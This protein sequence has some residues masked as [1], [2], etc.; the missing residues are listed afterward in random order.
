VRLHA[1]EL[2]PDEAGQEAVRRDWRALRE[3]G[4]PSQLDHPGATNAPHLTLVAAPSVEPVAE[5]AAELVPLPVEV[6]AAGLLLLGGE[7]VTVARALDVP[8]ALLAA[9][10][11]MRAGVP[12]LPHQGWL[13]H[14]TLARR[15]PRA[16]VQRAVEVLGHADTV[17]RMVHLRRWDPDAG[18]V[19]TVAEMP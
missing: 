10:L 19:T 11:E 3:A 14:V 8:D 9:V 13:P 18:T 17:L 1:L 4:L 16:E 6:R 7:R 12:D 15:V 2:L 5:R